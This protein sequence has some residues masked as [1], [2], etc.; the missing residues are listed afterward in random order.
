MYQKDFK[1]PPHTTPWV[2][3]IFTHT[4]KPNCHLYN[5]YHNTHTTQQTEQIEQTTKRRSRPV[6]ASQSRIQGPRRCCPDEGCNKQ[7]V[8][9]D[10]LKQHLQEV[11][12]IEDEQL[13]RKTLLSS[14]EVL[15]SN[16]EAEVSCKESSLPC[17]KKLIN[18]QKLEEHLEVFHYPDYKDKNKRNMEVQSI[19]LAS[20]GRIQDEYWIAPTMNHLICPLEKEN[21]GKHSK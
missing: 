5:T 14:K 8:F 12:Q 3:P 4:T 6:N 10:K 15:P 20:G 7:F 13:L 17:N 19:F 11:H 9:W 1:H 21:V 16:F 18:L 2:L